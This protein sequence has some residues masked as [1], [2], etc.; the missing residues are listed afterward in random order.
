MRENGCGSHG[1]AALP[2]PF[3]PFSSLT[4]Q[5]RRHYWIFWRWRYLVIMYTTQVI[6]FSV[7]YIDLAENEFAVVL[8]KEG[9]IFLTHYLVGYELPTRKETYLRHMSTILVI[10]LLS[11]LFERWWLLKTLGEQRPHHR[12]DA[13][14][15]LISYNSLL[16]LMLL[17]VSVSLLLWLKSFVTVVKDDAEY[18]QEQ[19]L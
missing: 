14:K 13:I 4:S 8:E 15:Y 7:Q 3:P 6:A 16:L 18:N 1:K 17:G 19:D 10:E 5:F 9:H 11:W 12:I 2:S